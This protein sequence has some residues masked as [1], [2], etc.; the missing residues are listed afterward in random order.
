MILGQVSFNRYPC[1]NGSLS[2]KYKT[3]SPV[4]NALPLIFGNIIFLEFSS[5]SFSIKHSKVESIID[6]EIIFSLISIWFFFLNNANLAEVPVPQ[7][8]LSNLPGL[9]N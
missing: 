2:S 7:G 9:V 4:I 1:G 8:D 3:C 5:I 6:W